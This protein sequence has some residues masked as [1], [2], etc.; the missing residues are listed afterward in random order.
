MKC[1]EIKTTPGQRAHMRIVADRPDGLHVEII[2]HFDGYSTTEPDIMPR[3]LFDV[4]LRTG[5][6]VVMPD[7]DEQGILAAVAS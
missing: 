2:R 7:A 5:Y 6:L 1:Y 3:E 4:C